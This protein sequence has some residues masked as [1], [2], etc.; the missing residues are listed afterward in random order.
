MQR[1]FGHQG[2]YQRRG[3]AQSHATII[4]NEIIELSREAE[5]N[6]I[7]N[8]KIQEVKG[9]CHRSKQHAVWNIGCK[10]KKNVL[11]GYITSG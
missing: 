3:P 11:Y 8:A 6:T 4:G 7:T 9:Q 5:K 2:I 10:H 1:P